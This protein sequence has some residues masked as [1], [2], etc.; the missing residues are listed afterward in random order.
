MA[1]GGCS[2]EHNGD[3]IDRALALIA[4]S[5]AERLENKTYAGFEGVRRTKFAGVAA[6]LAT[7][8][9]THQRLDQAACSEM[10]ASF[11]SIMLIIQQLLVASIEYSRRSGL[12]IAFNAATF[13]G[14][15][16]RLRP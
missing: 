11:T 1:A 13:H 10:F 16:S 2:W 3:S 12:R 4:R 15:Q 9:Y 14:Y 6:P 8:A 5:S 7:S